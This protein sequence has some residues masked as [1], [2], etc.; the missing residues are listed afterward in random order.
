MKKWW[1]VRAKVQA[2]T[3]DEA[4][5]VLRRESTVGV[6]EEEG[7]VSLE[8]ARETASPWKPETSAPKDG[9]A[10]IAYDTHI[11]FAETAWWSKEKKQFVNFDGNEAKFTLWMEQPD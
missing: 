10:F 5:K 1:C 2:A 3:R 4:I 11:K 7:R 6:W 8:E 9:R